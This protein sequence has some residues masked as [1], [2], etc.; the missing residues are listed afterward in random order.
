MIWVDQK[1]LY[2]LFITKIF[3]KEQQ[4]VRSQRSKTSVNRSLNK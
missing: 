4:R 2:L 1:L 3:R